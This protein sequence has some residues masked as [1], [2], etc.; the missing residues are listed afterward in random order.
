MRALLVL[1]DP[2]DNEKYEQIFLTDEGVWNFLKDEINEFDNVC[3]SKQLAKWIASSRNWRQL[4]IRRLNNVCPRGRNLYLLKSQYRTQPNMM[5][6]L[7]KNSQTSKFIELL[8]C[9]GTMEGRIFQRTKTEEFDS[10]LFII[11]LSLK[12][13]VNGKWTNNF[14]PAFDGN[15]LGIVNIIFFFV[16]EFPKVVEGHDP[17]IT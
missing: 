13:T 9:D 2:E 4:D 1:K 15:L 8:E 7:G 17:A 10:L 11:C 14:C 6:K 16:G 3:T 12:Y 5:L